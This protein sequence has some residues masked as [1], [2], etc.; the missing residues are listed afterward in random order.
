VVKRI[1]NHISENKLHNFVDQALG[2]HAAHK[3]VKC[4]P[5]TV[6]KTCFLM[7]ISYS[8]MCLYLSGTCDLSDVIKALEL[9]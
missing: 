5:P 4:G 6:L 2:L 1:S 3:V 7:K 9:I 8:I